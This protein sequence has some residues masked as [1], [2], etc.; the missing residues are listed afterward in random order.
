MKIRPRITAVPKK[1]VSDTVAVYTI[2]N[3]LR[4]K[5]VIAM[6]TIPTVVMYTVLMMY[7]ASS[8]PFT[9]MLRVRNASNS[10]IN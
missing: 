6:T 3:S 7:L 10:A 9:L 2:K 1:S 5:K 4:T 8:S